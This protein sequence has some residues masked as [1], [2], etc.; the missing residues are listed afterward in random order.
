M[1]LSKNDANY[2]EKVLRIYG[3]LSGELH[4]IELQRSRASACLGLSLAGNRDV[5][6]MSVFVFDIEPTSL[7]GRDGHIHIGDELLEINGHVLHGRSHLNA[8]AIIK[9]INSTRLKILI[10]RDKDFL[11][12][13]AVDP[14][15]RLLLNYKDSSSTLIPRKFKEE[16]E[17]EPEGEDDKNFDNIPRIDCQTVQVTSADN[18]PNVVKADQRTISCNL[19]NAQ[20]DTSLKSSA[21]INDSQTKQV[22]CTLTKPPKLRLKIHNASDIV[23][24]RRTHSKEFSDDGV[25]CCINDKLK[26]DGAVEVTLPEQPADDVQPSVSVVP[27]DPFTCPISS[28]KP[29]VIDIQ[30]GKRPLGVQVIGGRDTTLDSVFIFQIYKDGAAFL[31]GRLAVGD[32]ILEVNGEQLS[33]FTNF[34]VHQTLR[35]PSAVLR[36]VVLRDAFR[37]D[38]LYD[39]LEV[40]LVKRPGRG[41]GFSVVS[42]R[43]DVGVIVADIIKSNAAELDG[44]LTIGDEIVSVN[45]DNVCDAKLHD[46]AHLLKT[47]IGPVSLSVRRLRIGFQPAGLID[48]SYTNSCS[49]GSLLKSEPHPTDCKIVGRQITKRRQNLYHSVTTCL[50]SSDD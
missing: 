50:R 42:K 6:T 46:A 41:L 21:E 39:S 23:P 2:T 40:D 7:V 28:G 18:S 1:N 4:L 33:G 29:S 13:I 5:A 47:V 37:E 26:L 22:D 19:S 27:S 48:S 32:K 20:N 36:L 38:D 35:C 34:Q 24:E 15:T 8:S 25:S 10:L 49:E 31:D 43:D 3:D 44:R 30:K 45:G 12:R 16:N 17:N 14:V 9:G 11:Q